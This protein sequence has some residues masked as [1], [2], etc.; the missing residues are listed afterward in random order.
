M[1]VIFLAPRASAAHGLHAPSDSLTLDDMLTAQAAR[2]EG[3]SRV[4]LTW[5]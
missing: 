1:S 3:V 2:A 5:R 4:T